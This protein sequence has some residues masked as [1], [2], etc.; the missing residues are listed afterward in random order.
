MRRLLAL[1]IGLV[2]AVAS[3]WRFVASLWRF[4]K[5]CQK[6]AASVEVSSAA[7]VEKGPCHQDVSTSRDRWLSIIVHCVLCGGYCGSVQILP[8][9]IDHKLI[10]DPKLPG[11]AEDSMSQAA[12][13]IFVGY[14]AGSVLIS[15]A[16]ERYGSMSVMKWGTL[17]MGIAVVGMAMLPLTT[18]CGIVLF[19]TARLAAGIMMSVGAFS[20][21]F[22]FEYC[23]APWAQAVII[24]GNI[25][26]SVWVSLM[27]FSC[28]TWSYGLHPS[29]EVLL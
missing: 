21:T 15:A 29:L 9:L 20:Y 6:S 8:V 14:T 1:P 17:F 3:L 24:A 10:A 23:P 28:W 7:D 11:L 18:S 5:T 25:T 13:A 22:S 2:L 16:K 4:D 26:F 12:T 19:A 27:G